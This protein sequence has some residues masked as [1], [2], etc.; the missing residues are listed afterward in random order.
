M[1]DVRDID[2]GRLHF[3]GRLPPAELAGVLAAGDLHVYLTVPFVLSW[4][5][6]NA[7]ACG[8][9]VLGSDTA[10]VREVIRD[11]ENGLLF[12]FFDPDDLADRAA[13]VLGDLPAHRRLGGAAADLVRREY[14]MDATLPKML[15]LYDRARGV[16]RGLEAARPPARPDSPASP[17]AG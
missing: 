17:F 8:A 16:T 1:P 3:L 2:R 6:I 5:M 10:P 12:D 15:A 9:V 14:S 4:S 7:M 11:G 13:A